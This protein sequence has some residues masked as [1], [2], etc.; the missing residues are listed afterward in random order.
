MKGQEARDEV[1]VEYEGQRVTGMEGHKRQSNG[2][3]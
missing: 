3:T 2:G 1:T